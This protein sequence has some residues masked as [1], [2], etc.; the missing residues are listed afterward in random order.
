MKN[1]KLDFS[2]KGLVHRFGQNFENSSTLI[3]MQNRPKKGS[4]N[5]LVGKKFV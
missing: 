1:A 4:G 5:D 2:Q 3:F